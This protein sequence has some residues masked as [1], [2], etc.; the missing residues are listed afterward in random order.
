MEITI[1]DDGIGI[2]EDIN[3]ENPETFGLQL[4]NNLVAQIDGEIE[5]DRSHGTEFKITFKELKY[6]KRL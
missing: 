4:V 5:L 3:L 6:K 2:P 1:A